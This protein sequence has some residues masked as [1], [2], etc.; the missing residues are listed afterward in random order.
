[1]KI[2]TTQPDQDGKRWFLFWCPSC[3]SCHGAPEGIWTLSGTEDAPTLHPSL[4]TYANGRTDPKTG[5]DREPTCHVSVI[6]GVGHFVSPSR[7]SGQQSPLTDW[8]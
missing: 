7:L 5:E 8:N 4:V 6:A 2:R 3:D 1:M